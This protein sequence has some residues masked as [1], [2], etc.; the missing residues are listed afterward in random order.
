LAKSVGRSAVE[1]KGAIATVAESFSGSWAGWHAELYYGDFE[2][3]PWNQQFDVEFGGVYGVPHGW[4]SWTKAG[5][6]DRVEELSHQS[7]DEM[8]QRQWALARAMKELQSDLLARLSPVL[9]LDGM[10]REKDLLQK[11]D[12]YRWD[13][14]AYNAFIRAA[15]RR[16]RRM[17]TRDSEARMQGGKLPAH[18]ECGALAYSVE[19]FAINAEEFWDLA[20]RLV[21]QLKAYAAMSVQPP[22]RSN[23]ALEV[24]L[25]TCRMFHV[26]ATELLSRYD[27][28]STL[29]INDEY[30]VQDLLRALLWQHFDDVRREE[31]TPSCAG[32]APR[33]DL[34]LKVEKIAVETKMTRN[35]LMDKEIGDELLQDIGRYKSHPDC[36]TLVCFIY[37]PKGLLKNPHGLAADLEKQ[38]DGRLIVRVI[39]CPGRA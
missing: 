22:L 5:V 1:V 25:S 29:T 32:R 15:T 39:I 20:L 8:L 24:A 18:V 14:S 6:F 19:K 38:S 11:L 34:L 4:R 30:D 36:A 23:D 10:N 16:A 3:P 17:T 33:M 12:G 31:P 28:R 35:G 13:E 9:N 27:K 21:K 2:R 7:L 37:D 26:V